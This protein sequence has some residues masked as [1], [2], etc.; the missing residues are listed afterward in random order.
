MET[1]ENLTKDIISNKD[2]NKLK[3]DLH[4]GITRYDHS[5]RVA[6]WTYKICKLFSMKNGEKTT[7]AALLHDFYT[8]AWQDSYELSELDDK[9]RVNFINPKRKK[10]FEKHGFTHP[11]EAL[12]NSRTYFKKYLNKDIENAIVTHMFPLSLFTKYKLPNNKTSFVITYI[13]KKV[14][15][16][17][18]SSVKGVLKYA[19][20]VKVEK[21]L[22]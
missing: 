3:N 7:R 12:E 9:Y 2:F 4:H 10:L 14:S 13:D 22:N 1:F 18:V 11:I 15:M 8:R 16:N 21:E 20:L 17:V 5:Y 6:K 19:G